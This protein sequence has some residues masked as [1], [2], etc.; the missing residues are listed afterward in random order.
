MVLMTADNSTAVYADALPAS[1]A[2]QSL[3]LSTDGMADRHN[4]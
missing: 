2:Y 3:L 1:G 4:T